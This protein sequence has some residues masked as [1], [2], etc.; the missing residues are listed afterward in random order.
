MIQDVNILLSL[1][2]TELRDKYNSL[3]EFKENTELDANEVIEFL[4]N[5]GYYYDDAQNAFKLKI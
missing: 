2:N 1:V 5:S 3:N 4:N